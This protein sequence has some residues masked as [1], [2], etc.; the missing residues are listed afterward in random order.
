MADHE[1]TFGKD[2]NGGWTPGT[3]R[4]VAPADVAVR[5][6]RQE[7]KARHWQ[8]LTTFGAALMGILA[9]LIL[10]SCLIF[11]IATANAPREP[12]RIIPSAAKVDIRHLLKKHGL[13]GQVSFVEIRPAG[14]LWFERDGQLCQLK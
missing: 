5:S 1:D 11:L 12:Q 4:R 7:H 13:L 9:I 10:G 2:L 8:I 6:S 3:I 14:T